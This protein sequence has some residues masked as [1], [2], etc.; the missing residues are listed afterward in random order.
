[1]PSASP[2][3]PITDAERTKLR[4]CKWK[5][6]DIAYKSVEEL[7]LHLEISKDRAKYLRALAIFQSIPSIGPIIAQAVVEL[8]YYSLEDLEQ[9]SGVELID[10]LE[11]FY[12][13]WHDP[14]VEDA[15]RCITYHAKHPG[16]NQSWF[17]F[18]DE[19]KKYRAE[20]G[21]PATRPT[22]AWHEVKSKG[23]SSFARTYP[24]K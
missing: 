15:M 1:M 22:L 14:C 13:Y 12:G 5:L 4:A 23:E 18:T 24:R 16:S 11:E 2:K 17:D 6:K 20:H 8:G 3:L 21:Y 9:V 19:R 10:R 7:S